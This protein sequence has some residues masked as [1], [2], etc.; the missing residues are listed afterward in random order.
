L[1]Q[2]FFTCPNITDLQGAERLVLNTL[3][4]R[5]MF[6]TDWG[7]EPYLGCAA[8][9]GSM[10]KHLATTDV[11]WPNG[12]TIDYTTDQIYWIDAKQYNKT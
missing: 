2:Y 8:M 7:N 6:W 4:F 1:P 10:R 12:L 11:Y 9:D 3:I 5:L